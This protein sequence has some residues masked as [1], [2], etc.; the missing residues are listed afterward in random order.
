[1]WYSTLFVVGS[2]IIVVVTYAITATL[3]TQRDQQI[4]NAKVGQ[5][6]DVYARGGLRLLTATVQAALHGPVPVDAIIGRHAGQLVRHGVSVAIGMRVKEIRRRG[7]RL[8]LTMCR[9]LLMPEAADL[10]E[11]LIGTYLPNLLGLTSGLPPQPAS[12]VFEDREA[13]RKAVEAFLRRHGT[14]ADAGPL[15]DWIQAR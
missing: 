5:Y 10:H 15:L 11:N 1:M 8:A 14:D 3:L 9:V 13:E 6:A 4:V 12:R 2:L 7:Q